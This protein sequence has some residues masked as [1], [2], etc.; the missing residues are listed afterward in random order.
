MCFR[1]KDEPA[2]KHV[3]GIKIDS[4]YIMGPL[5]PMHLAS[6]NTFQDRSFFPRFSG[7]RGEPEVVPVKA[8]TG[9]VFGNL[10]DAT[11]LLK[12]LAGS[13]SRSE[14]LKNSLA[15]LAKLGQG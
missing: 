1:P 14:F 10:P 11:G 3:A 15:K 5:K 6:K 9:C 4:S 13:R 2:W 7:V 8:E 12:L